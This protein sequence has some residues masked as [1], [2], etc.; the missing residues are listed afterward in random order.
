MDADRHAIPLPQQKWYKGILFDTLRIRPFGTVKENLFEDI[1]KFP[2][3]EPKT[4]GLHTNLSQYGCL[5]APRAFQVFH[6]GVAFEGWQSSRDIR[7]VLGNLRLRLVFGG[8]TT[9]EESALSAFPPALFVTDGIASRQ[10]EDE[11]AIACLKVISEG[12]IWTNYLRCISSVKGTSLFIDSTTSFR[13]E[14]QMLPWDLDGPVSL[15]VMLTGLDLKY[16]SPPW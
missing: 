3:G 9:M 5:G 4:A 7:S 11:Q 15:K 2:D 16:G 13:V 10:I 14:A 6:W 8:D 1:Q 12:G